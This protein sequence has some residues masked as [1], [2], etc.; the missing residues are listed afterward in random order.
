VDRPLPAS[1]EARLAAHAAA[2][3]E[4]ALRAVLERVTRRLRATAWNL[5]HNAHDAQDL[6]QEALL[7]ITRP[8]V[9]ARYRGEGS[10]DGYLVSVGVRA[11]ISAGRRSRGDREQSTPSDDLPDRVAAPVV[12]PAIVSAPVRD[13]LTDLPERARAI[14]LLIA[15]GDL[16]YEEVAQAL[17]MEVGTVKSAYSR[18][19]SALRGR[20]ASADLG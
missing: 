15:V 20:L 10:F 5:S 2:G 6:V 8:D 4:R 7:K 1:E 16:S 19:R 12:E 14:V 9:L 11:M 13:A 17:D 3:D 18:A